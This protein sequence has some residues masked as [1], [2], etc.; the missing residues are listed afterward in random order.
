MPA[1]V[2]SSETRRTRAIQYAHRNDSQ[3][4]VP[5]ETTVHL[6][7]GHHPLLPSVSTVLRISPWQA[8]PARTT[9]TGVGRIIDGMTVRRHNR[10]A[11][12]DGSQPLIYPHLC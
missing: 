2:G 11:S 4:A 6:E 7:V 9:A 12:A 5:S 1:V 3:D 10:T 8:T